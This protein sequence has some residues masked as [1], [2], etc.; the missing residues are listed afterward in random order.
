MFGGPSPIYRTTDGGNTWAGISGLPTPVAKG[1]CG[2]QCV[3]ANTIYVVGRI[4]GPSRILKSTNGGNNWFYLNVDTSMAQRLVDLKFFTPDSG[5]V[6][7][8]KGPSSISAPV[9]L[10]T[11]DGGATW[12]NKFMGTNL[13]SS[14][15]IWKIFFVNRSYAIGSFNQSTAN[16]QFVKSTDG[17]MTWN[18]FSQAVNPAMFTQGIGFV[19]ESTGW[20]GGGASTY[21]TSNG[22]T[23]WTNNTFGTGINRIRF[24][25]DTLGYASGTGF[26]K[27]T[28]DVNIKVEE[29]FSAVSEN[30]KLYQNYPNPFNPTTTI[31]YEVKRTSFVRII[32]YNPIGEEVRVLKED[33]ESIGTY[34]IMWDG[35]NNSG[36]EAASGMYY[37]VFEAG[38]YKETRKMVL[39]R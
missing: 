23:N 10:F 35:R 8:G 7:G 9:I 29:N 12:I 39:V 36:S 31:N 17:G 32:I 3:G 26:Y 11:S 2:I 25:S 27:Y 30:F 6:T 22:G 16:L 20:V 33:P 18:M 13:S 15:A 21:Y 19:N 5:F 14:Q 38:E 34:E 4:E 28:A 1:F 37:L 24:Y